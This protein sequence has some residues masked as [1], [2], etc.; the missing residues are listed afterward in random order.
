[1]STHYDVIII[2]TGAGGGTLFHALASTGK[3]ILLLERGGYVP[4][5][6]D[7]WSTRAV[8]RRGP[9][10]HQGGLARRRRAR[11]PPA[12]Q[13]LRRRQHQVLRRGALP[14]AP[15]GLRRD[16]A[17]R[18]HL[19]RLAHRLRGPRAL[20]HAGRA[21]LPRPRRARRRSDGAA[22]ERAVPAPG[23]EPRAA[24]PAALATI[25]RAWACGRF[26]SRSASCSTSRTR[27]R[28]GASA[29]RPATASRASS[30]PSRTPRWSAWTRRSRS[31]RT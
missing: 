25:W 27:R 4:R 17:P 2:G 12:H 24:H 19:A 26:T 22:G 16:Q 15:R 5:E 31:T 3:R 11:S 6:K 9:V 30:T 10:Q 18:R 21:A 14:P 7:N 28:A 8:N 1:M 29:A 23:G 20:L 13:L